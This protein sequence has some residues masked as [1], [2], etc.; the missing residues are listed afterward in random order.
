M[1]NIV[2]IKV[3]QFPRIILLIYVQVCVIT[4][5]ATSIYKSL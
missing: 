5:D 4:I 2:R 1:Y 3:S